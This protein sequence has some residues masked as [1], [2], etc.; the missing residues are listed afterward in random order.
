M[1]S[2]SLK[3]LFSSYHKYRYVV[4]GLTAAV[5]LA[6]AIYRG[7][8]QAKEKQEAARSAPGVER[9][10]EAARGAAKDSR[11]GESTESHDAVVTAGHLSRDAARPDGK[12]RFWITI[13]NKSEASIT[14]V[15]F[16]DFF[17]PGFDRPET[18]SGG[19]S[20][21]TWGQICATLPP[22]A[23]IAIWG[24]L[25]AAREGA[26][27]EN[28]FAVLIWDSALRPSQSAVVQLGEVERL[29]WY[30][31]TWRWF[32]QLDVGLPTLTAMLIAL[33]G[34]FN[35]RKDERQAKAKEAL[36]QREASEKEKRER[37]EHLDAE[38]R[39]QYQ[40]TWNLMLPQ[41]NRLSLKYYIPTANA[42][43]TAI[44]HLSACREANG[45]TDENLLAGLFGLVQMQWHRLRMKRAIGGYYFKSRTAE[46]VMEGLFQKHR[47]FFEVESP[48][49][50][51]VLTKF[52]KPFQRRYELGDFQVDRASWDA[53]QEQFWSEFCHWVPSDNCKND[54]VAMSAMYNTLWYE[55]NRPFLNWY[56]EQPPV[57][58]TR[59]ELDMIGAVAAGTP[60][61]AEY[62]NEISIGV[63][64]T[65][66]Q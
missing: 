28:A 55:S 27:K 31:A 18:L 60:R 3:R 61:L 21:A 2:M 12:I 13:Q 56:Q 44:Y 53:D 34:W 65:P 19:C 52:V 6:V 4:L 43:L 22:Q 59:E 40:Q 7:S 23:T 17:V 33:Y 24:D 1:H 37:K 8:L 49:R 30:A 39:D 29:S 35:K 5:L 26:P 47:K 10:Q 45:A 38:R 66:S 41:A 57:V 54:L 42:T 16:A 20:G 63:P 11:R 64:A 25:S 50:Y 51:I 46:A 32:S 62:L 58:L 36:A 15:R 14:N 48:K 9:K